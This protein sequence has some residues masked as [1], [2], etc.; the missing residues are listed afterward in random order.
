MPKLLER[1]L[2][3][4]DNK[5]LKTLQS[6]V[7]AVNLLEEEFRGLTDDELRAETERFKERLRDGETLNSLLPEAFAAVR[8]A[9]DRTLGQRHYDVQIMG[10]VALHLG[11]IAE[12]GTG[13]GKTLVATAPAYLNALA[14]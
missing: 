13:E 6:Y 11:N 1:V 3:T 9:A 7:N 5:I 14:G 2:K 12:M 10:G 8:E 4:G